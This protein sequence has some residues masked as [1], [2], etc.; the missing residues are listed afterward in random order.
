VFATE[1]KNNNKI[2]WLWLL[3]SLVMWYT[4]RLTLVE[5][6]VALLAKHKASLSSS[7]PKK[8]MAN[9]IGDYFYEQK[10]SLIFQ[11]SME[12]SPI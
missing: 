11:P 6:L 4:T 2:L 5:S 8:I 3:F 1:N 7:P 9:P 10:K 12:P